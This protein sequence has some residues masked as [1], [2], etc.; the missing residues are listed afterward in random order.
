MVPT[1]AV[2]ATPT[3]TLPASTNASQDNQHPIADI[4][5]PKISECGYP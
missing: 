5:I 4:L 1:S 3:A 2:N